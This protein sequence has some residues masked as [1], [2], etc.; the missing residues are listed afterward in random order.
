MEEEDEKL[1]QMHA[2]LDQT[3]SGNKRLQKYSNFD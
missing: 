3:D 1:K 2:E